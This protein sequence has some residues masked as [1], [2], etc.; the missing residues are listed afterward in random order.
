M[1]RKRSRGGVRYAMFGAA[2][3]TASLALTGA[4]LGVGGP[5]ILGG[6]D[7][8]DHGSFDTVA[9]QN[10]QGWLY[11]QRALE[12]ISPKV[13][14]ANDGSVA[15]LG[16][17][18]DPAALS[19]DCG[20]AIGHA[21][22]KAG[23]TVTYHEGAAAINTFF[24][25]LN[26][27]AVNPKIIWIAGVGA[28]NCMDVDEIGAL[29]ANATNID[30]FVNQ[31]G[32]LMSHGDDS[33]YGTPTTPGWLNALIPGIEAVGGG[34]SGDLELT[35]KGLLA[36]PGVTNADV[37][38]GPW[39]NWFRGD[40]GGLDVLVQTN[41][42]SGGEVLPVPVGSAVVLGGGQVSLTLKPADVGV[43]KSAPAVADLQDVISYT[44]TVT[45]NGPNPASG[46][47]VTDTLPAGMVFSAANPSQGTCTGG[48]TVTCTLGDMASGA[49][50]TVEIKATATAAGTVTNTARVE[51]GVPDPNAAN[52]TAQAT[53]NVL[54][55]ALKVGVT[56]PKSAR[57][58]SVVTYR[59]TVTNTSGRTAKS[60]VL[61]NPLPGGVAIAS[62]SKGARFSKATNTW[63]FG[64]IA[65]SA[66][67]TVS[68]RLR[69][70]RDA[71]GSKCLTGTAT[72][73]NASPA[74]GRRCT[75]VL[76]VAGVAVA[77]VTG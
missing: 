45:N 18:D 19:G 10:I 47:K 35:P 7:L 50:A 16:A 75:T 25:Q 14:R 55:A 20:G 2:A 40:L 26:A 9:N 61:R 67:R 57:A 54:L 28:A 27:G 24:T 23:L 56:G 51:T 58:G 12:N 4:A 69:L 72:A 37:N 15:A 39:H 77:P 74:T 21:A 32:G 49:T 13:G 52:D 43:A 63:S 30:K 68:V 34:S 8:Q 44:L 60:V 6:D 31:G 76:R 29:T 66:S 64:N 41:A 33:V 48:P 17:A 73:V 70:D 22:A 3:A 59:L 46:V 71:R 62:R 42:Q 5:V 36:F 38:A 65:P 53:T 1:A 11:I